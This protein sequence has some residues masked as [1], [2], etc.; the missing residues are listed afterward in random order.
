MSKKTSV[1]DFV[2]AVAVDYFSPLT[3]LFNKVFKRTPE[4]T[5]KPDETPPK[6]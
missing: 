5:S 6:P 2:K 3:T 4:K 1:T